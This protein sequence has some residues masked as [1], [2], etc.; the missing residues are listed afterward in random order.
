MPTEQETFPTIK[1]MQI[2][3][4]TIMLVMA[5]ITPLQHIMR[6]TTTPDMDITPT[7]HH[8]TLATTPGDTDI[9]RE[10]QDITLAS[11]GPF[12]PHYNANSTATPHPAFHNAGYFTFPAANHNAGLTG[13]NALA[14]PSATPHPNWP[15]GAGGTGGT[16]G[17]ANAG[18]TGVTGSDGGVIII[19]RNVGTANTQMSHSNFPYTK[20]IDI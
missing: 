2:Q 9:M 1:Q 18:G 12:A 14:N 4:K 15:G 6:G 8:I 11:S 20:A 7:R 13:S 16:A 17:T 3:A 10:I 19:A 5:H